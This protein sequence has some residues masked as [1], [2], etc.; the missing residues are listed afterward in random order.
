MSQCLF[1]R[2]TYHYVKSPSELHPWITLLY[3]KGIG[4]Q[5]YLKLLDTIGSP[6]RILQCSIS[7]LENM[8]GLSKK[9][10]IAIKDIPAD[11]ASVNIDWLN[12][13]N[14]HQIITIEDSEYPTQ[15]KRIDNPPPVLFVQGD[16]TILKEPQLAIVGSRN[17]TQGGRDNAYEFAKYLARNGLCI[18]SGLALGIDG[19]SHKGA[20]DANAPTVSVVATGLDRVYPARH[21]EL[22]HH[23]SHQGVLVSE[24]TIG[25][26]VRA[27]NFPRRNRIISGLSVGT[28]VIEAAIKSGSLIT[29]KYAS[30]QGREVFA[31][32]GS[33]HNPLARG[34]HH[35]IRQGAKLVETAEHILEEVGPALIPFLT[36]ASLS[37][38]SQSS[39]N[40]ES[41]VVTEITDPDQRLILE[42]MGYDP[43]PIDT[44]VVQTGLTIE[45]VSSILLI[46]E[47]QG[48]IE[49]CGGGRYSRL[50][51]S[52]SL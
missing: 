42:M 13:N 4:S 6:E 16:V 51:P 29:A 10:A 7:Q 39:S 1:K 40:I 38:G 26:P 11:S 34:C 14:T 3:A 44:L 47:L 5:R 24:Y 19:F 15:L 50:K 36:Q 45:K 23:I 28:L 9:Q 21:R 27:Q 48:Q 8:A 43:I 22:A 17:P 41:V 46:L 37:S 2:T 18:T 25:T 32:P 20:L 30:E 33:I 52:V 49:A 12:T 31:I 35:L